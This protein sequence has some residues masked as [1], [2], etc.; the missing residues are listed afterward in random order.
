MEFA[1]TAR[2]QDGR[3]LRGVLDASSERTARERLRDRGLYVTELGARRAPLEFQLRRRVKQDELT[4]ISRQLSAMISAGIPIAEALSIVADEVA[5]VTLAEALLQMRTD[6]HQG[7]SLEQ[8]LAKHPRIFPRVFRQL[9]HVAETGGALDDILEMLANYME[10][11]QDLR[12]QVRSAFAYPIAV[13]GVAVLT[14]IALLIF[15]VPVFRDV[16]ARLGLDLPLATRGLIFTADLVRQYWWAMPALVVGGAIGIGRLR[17][18]QAG[19]RLWDRAVLH[20]PIMGRLVRKVAISRW[21][22]ACHILVQSGVPVASSLSASADA[23]GNTLIAD[24]VR[25]VTENL[26]KGRDIASQ[27]RACGEFPPIV[28]EMVRAG[29]ES[30]SLDMMLDKC[31]S[32]CERDIR[33]TTKRILVVLEP[34]MM[35]G[36]GLLIAFIALSMYLPYFQLIGGIR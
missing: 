30:G 25:D 4:I 16:F 9:V 31:A 26:Q 3:R 19:L 13:S 11:E 2:D 7:A 10:D 8:A 12:E 33:H 15:V 17:A 22:R 34:I 18:S 29:E 28:V 20:L 6:I 23:A 35:V 5:N 36:I 32:Y 1:Y 21:V 24:S 14:V 27:L